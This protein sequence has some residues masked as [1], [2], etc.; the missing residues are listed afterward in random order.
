MVFLCFR[1]TENITAILTEMRSPSLGGRGEDL[2]ELTP[3]FGNLPL[4]D[5]V[6]PAKVITTDYHRQITGISGMMNINYT[7]LAFLH[8]FKFHKYK[9]P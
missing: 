4:T 2:L 3:E 9:K 1:K 6:L 7:Q 8:S 5:I